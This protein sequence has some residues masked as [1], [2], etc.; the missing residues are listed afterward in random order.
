MV[1]YIPR[2]KC[3]AQKQYASD[4]LTMALTSP[5]A[6]AIAPTPQKQCRKCQ[7]TKPLTEFHRQRAGWRPR[8]KSCRN[9]SGRSTNKP[10]PIPCE[11]K[12]AALFAAA[13]VISTA[14]VVPMSTKYLYE[15]LAAQNGG[16]CPFT[17]FTFL[18]IR[19]RMGF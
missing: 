17:Y 12:Y 11:I 9:R 1:I 15:T 3:L 10:G 5:V 13:K 4:C 16:S 19:K 7:V 6:P 2:T 18:Q 14:A 8:C